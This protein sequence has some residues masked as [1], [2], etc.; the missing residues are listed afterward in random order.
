MSDYGA[1]TFSLR[2]SEIMKKANEDKDVSKEFY[3][4]YDELKK[5]ILK[6]NNV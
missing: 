6:Q 3:E 5:T 4:S 1:E 2:L